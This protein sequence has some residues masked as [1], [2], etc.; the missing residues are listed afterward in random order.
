MLKFVIEIFKVIGELLGLINRKIDLKNA[1]DIKNAKK[2]QDEV[3]IIN[4]F[5]K[6]VADKNI[7]KSRE[8]WSG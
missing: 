2:Q 3:D 4:K 6:N 5:E 1:Q 7:E 8:D